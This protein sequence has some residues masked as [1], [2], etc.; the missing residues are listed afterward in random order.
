LIRLAVLAAA[1][2][3]APAG[4]ARADD[5]APLG[6]EDVV[7]ML[8]GR[9]TTRFSP[10]SAPAAGLRSRPTWWTSEDRRRSGRRLAAMKGAPT[11]RLEG[12][13]RR[14]PRKGT[15]HLVVA[16]DG[17]SQ[18]LR[19]PSFADED[20]KGSPSCRR[21]SRRGRPAV[22]LRVRSRARARSVAQKS[23]L[24]RDTS[25][26]VRHEMLAFVP[27]AR[28]RQEAQ[29]PLPDTLEADVDDLGARLR[30]RCRRADR[31]PLA[32]GRQRDRKEGQDERRQKPLSAHQ[33][34]ADAVDLRDRVDRAVNNAIQSRNEN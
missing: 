32:R 1:L 14:T 27:R 28:R 6:N 26:T 21:I 18:T 20:L 3:V 25:L 4:P 11:R 33:L 10:R 8:S 29:A 13:G 19:A 15:V 24:G 5:P 16:F 2:V 34:Q 22:F 23:P 30:R 31:R 7:R 12:T 17:G 9:T